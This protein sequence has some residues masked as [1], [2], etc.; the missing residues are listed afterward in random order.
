MP[1]V[2]C[3]LMNELSLFD[4]LRLIGFEVMVQPLPTWMLDP[5]HDAAA[6]LQEGDVDAWVP[7]GRTRP[8]R[9]DPAR[10]LAGAASHR[11]ATDRTAAPVGCGAHDAS[12]GGRTPASGG[13]HVVF[14]SVA[15]SPHAGAAPG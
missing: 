13:G 15:S 12:D 2:F 6:Q 10:G 3:L 5:L 8:G 7:P 14:V 4:R 11:R 1:V 9:R